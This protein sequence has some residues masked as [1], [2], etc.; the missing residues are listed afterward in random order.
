MG[1]NLSKVFHN[2]AVI[3]YFQVLLRHYF[4]VISYRSVTGRAANEGVGIIT[5]AGYHT[6]T[7]SFKH[8]YFFRIS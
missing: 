6:P 8:T 3:V 2:I 5:I 7:L 1:K 4:L